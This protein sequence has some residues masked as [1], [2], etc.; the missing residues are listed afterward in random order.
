MGVARTPSPEQLSEVRPVHEAGLVEIGHRVGTVPRGEQ[1]CEV[2]TV[3]HPVAVEVAEATSIGTP[4]VV[5][6]APVVTAT[7]VTF[8]SA[9]ATVTSISATAIAIAIA[10]D[11]H[12]DEHAIDPDVHG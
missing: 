10:I 6:V 2:A 5:A 7:V 8:I 1:G 3:H 11:H 12:V 9:I 4:A